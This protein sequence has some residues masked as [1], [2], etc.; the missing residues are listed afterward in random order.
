MFAPRFDPS[1][2]TFLSW[3]LLLPCVL[4]GCP[5]KTIQYPAE[6]ER[7]LRIDQ[8]LE[9]LRSAYQQKDR[10]RFQAMLLP[11]NQL[12]ELKRQV[13][14]DFEAFSAI[15]LEFKIERVVIEKDD[16]DVF[17]HWQGTWKR[18]A[19]DVGIRQRGY[20]RLQWAGT[21]SILLRSAQGDLP[22]GMKTKQMLSEPLS[23]PTPPQ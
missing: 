5:S 12:D 3:L 6:H 11:L 4:G 16:I 7:L 10:A 2:V 23:P 19:G 20:A 22:F 21:H 9:S 17:I 13:D 1:P 14:M 15:S 18:S 8:A